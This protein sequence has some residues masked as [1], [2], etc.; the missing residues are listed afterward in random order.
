VDALGLAAGATPF[1]TLLAAAAA[2]LHRHGAAEDLVL[3]SPIANRTRAEIEGLIG[4]FT[5]TVVL[6]TDLGG[7]PSWRELLARARE[8]TLGAYEHQELPFERIVEELVPERDMSYN[9]LFQVMVALQNAPVSTLSLPGLTL[10]DWEVELPS[11]RFDL[12][13]D[14]EEERHWSG[15]VEYPTDLFDATTV[16]RMIGNF[17]RLLAGA[18]ARPDARLSELPLLSATEERQLAGWSFGG[19]VEREAACL[20]ELFLAQ[21]RRTPA[22]EALRWGTE[23]LS[24]GELLAR[25]ERLAGGLRALGVGPETRVAVCL[26]RTPALPVAL[27]AVLAAG[28]AYV[29]LDPTYPRERLQLMLQDSGAA[30]LLA[31][32]GAADRLPPIRTVRLDPS[33]R[34]DEIPAP[35][36][37]G[38]A[39]VPDNL[40]YLIYTSGSTGTPKGVALTHRS[41]VAFVRWARERWSAAELSG[42]LF[43][44]SVSFDLSIFELFVPLAAGGRVILADN[45][46]ALPTLPAAREVTLLNTV[47]SALTE[48]VRQGAVPPSVRTVNLAGEALPRTLVDALYQ[49]GHVE[50]VWNLYGPSEDTTYSTAALQPRSAA[51]DRGWRAAVE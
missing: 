36:P 22:A 34:P 12:F 42:V 40:A 49:L 16:L 24:Y 7:D 38:L 27:L 45:A 13:V 47:P 35:Q 39:P 43:A 9:P 2:W 37:A 5:N 17:E 28:G 18:V 21:A 44:T 3:G 8:V 32:A 29:P 23:R 46:L 1:M 26:E 41:A 25:V 4:F 10:G 33:G 6:R 14:M 11:A 15:S 48:L 20:H 30:L 50:R 31:A 19:P 51:A